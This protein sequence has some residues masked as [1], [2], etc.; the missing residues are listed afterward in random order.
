MKTKAPDLDQSHIRAIA[1]VLGETGLGFSNREIEEL[2]ATCRMHDP[3]A[4]LK[5]NEYI[6]RGMNKRDRIYNAFVDGVNK[7]QKPNIV[8]KFIKEAMQPA[9]HLNK[10]GRHQYFMGALNEIL[11]LVG[12]KIGED[13]QYRQIKTASTPAEATKRALSLKSILIERNTHPA[14]LKFCQAEL[15]EDNYFHAV[16]EAAKS[17][18]QV[19]RDK[20]GL[21]GD[22]VRLIE[23]AF[24]T[25]KGRSYPVLAI[26][27]FE[28]DTDTSEHYGLMNIIIG[29]FKMFRNPT[30]HEP[31]IYWPINEQDA[32]EI[33]G[34]IS[35]A[36]RKLDNAFKTR[37]TT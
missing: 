21:K 24:N 7:S 4:E 10:A 3:V 27:K 5:S 28:S 13:A 25:S 8:Y 26:N 19:I 37:Y 34:T 23:E 16:L 11:S 22:G 29:V 15:L 36:H 14:V 9:R 6:Y 1:D 2:L 32:L 33:L 18:G 12:L 17:L 35:F 31:K 20:S 30:A